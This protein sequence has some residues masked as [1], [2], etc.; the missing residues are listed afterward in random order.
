MRLGMGGKMIK[1]IKLFVILSLS[2]SFLYSENIKKNEPVKTE[3][4]EDSQVK[5]NL[6]EI[7]YKLVRQDQ[8]LDETIY[9]VKAKNGK[10][11]DEDTKSLL[12]GIKKVKKQMDEVSKLNKE[13]LIKIK[14]GAEIAKYT[15]TIMI[16]GNKIDKKTNY[17]ISFLSKN[18]SKMRNAPISNKGY[19]G[20]KKFQTIMEEQNRMEIVKKEI[21]SLKDFSKKLKANGKWLYIASR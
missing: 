12:S 4:S 10:L 20:K 8:Y 17:L 14:Q 9:A 1:I 18:Q 13:Q 2:T 7:L 5:E 6:K 11:N 19:K 15:K 16:Y 3:I 21:V